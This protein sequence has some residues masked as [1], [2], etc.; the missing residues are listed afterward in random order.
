MK[1]ALSW[2][3][4]A[5]IAA[6]G[7]RTTLGDDDLIGDASVSDVTISIDGGITTPDSGVVVVDATVPIGDASPS[8][9]G[10]V[11]IDSGSGVACGNT[12]CTITQYCCVTF[13]G[14]QV[15]ETCESNG[16]TCQGASLSCTSAANCG[17]NE[18]CCATVQQQNISASCQPQCAGGFQNPQLC[19]S[20]AECPQGEQCQN[21]PFGFK[22]CRP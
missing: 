19:A 4:L 18:V 7:G 3:F 9:G 15:Q 16:S 1:R 8:D 17:S 14:Q 22:I 5:A 21:G 12:T 20:S 11:V 2:V 13:A 10:V 6:C